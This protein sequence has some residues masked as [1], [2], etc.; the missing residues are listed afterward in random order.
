MGNEEKIVK[1]T[2]ETLEK[3]VIEKETVIETTGAKEETERVEYAF[4]LN[5]F[6]IQKF[7]DPYQILDKKKSPKDR[8]ARAYVLL[9]VV[10]EENTFLIP[11]KKDVRGCPPQ[12]VDKI[13]YSVPSSTKPN[14]GLDFRKMIIVNDES[15][16]RVDEA[17]IS[18]SQ[19]KIIQDNFQDIKGRAIEYIKE[20]KK[21]AMKGRNKKTPLYSH[22]ALNNF[23]DELG[24]K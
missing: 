20:F 12:W 5:S 2:T 15:L 22:S 7:N 23:L 17:H 11:L 18:K 3:V 14:A 6:F 1:K 8:E 10:F 16:Y 19:K 9:K 21:A 24:I 4:L 13:T